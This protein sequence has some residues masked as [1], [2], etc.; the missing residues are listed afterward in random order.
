M[1]QQML[2]PTSDW[3][4]IFERFDKDR[5]GTI[6]RLELKQALQAFGYNLN[7]N[8]MGSILHRYDVKKCGSIS[9]DAFLHCCVSIRSLTQSFQKYDTAKVFT[10]SLCF[11][12][13]QTHHDLIEWHR[14]H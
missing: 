7:D 12:S 4:A 2:I 5:S 8:V 1:K 6:D 3:L 14:D 13:I 10:H 11:K 9:F